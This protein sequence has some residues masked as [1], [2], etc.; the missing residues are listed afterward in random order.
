LQIEAWW[1][2]YDAESG[3]RYY[4]VALSES[5]LSEDIM[6]FTKVETGTAG[7]YKKYHPGLFEGQ[8]FYFIVKVTNQALLQIKQVNTCTF[9]EDFK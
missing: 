1:S 9:V 7:H 5:P 3:I 4:E 6:S 2:G 8:I